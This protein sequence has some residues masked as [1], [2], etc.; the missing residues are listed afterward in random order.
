MV[1]E[2]KATGND[3]KKLPPGEDDVVLNEWLRATAAAW[4]RNCR[5]RSVDA[6][7]DVAGAMQL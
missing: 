5:R 2:G 3:E 7:G 6:S 4:H 1:A